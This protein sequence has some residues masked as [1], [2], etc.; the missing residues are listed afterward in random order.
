MSLVAR[1]VAHLHEHGIVHRDLKPANILLDAAGQPYVTDFGLAAA[2]AG[3]GVTPA[4]VIAGT[5]SYMSPEQ[6]RGGS[7]TVGPASDVFSLGAILYELLTGAPPF[8]RETTLLTLEDVLV[9]EPPLP[10][11]VNPAVP[12]E[13]EWICLRCLRKAPARRYPS[14]AALAED[15]EQILRGEPV[16]T[17]APRPH[18]RMAHWARRAPALAMRLLAIGLFYALALVNCLVCHA[19]DSAWLLHLTGVLGLWVA[20]SVGLQQWLERPGRAQTAMFV[21]GAVDVVALSWIVWL[22]DGAAS[23][24]VVVFPL[25][26]AASGLWFQ[27]AYVRFVTGLCLAAYVGLIADAHLFRPAE[28]Q[29]RFGLRWDRH[30]DCLLALLLTGVVVSYLVRRVRALSRYLRKCR[31]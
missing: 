16:A 15:L 30:S 14:A 25:V 24:L 18:E 5:P 9:K 29:Q 17:Q 27:P 1:A 22:T 21:W 19:V 4:G 3:E 23:R 11:S 8:R 20:A 7:A 12:R 31:A 10:R 13:L 28:W 6:A 26:I 2:F